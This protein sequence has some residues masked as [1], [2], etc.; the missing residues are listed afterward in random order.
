MTDKEKLV[1]RI[2]QDNSKLV[3]D[4]KD[5]IPA[6]WRLEGWR[7][8]LTLEQNFRRV[9]NPE[10]ITRARRKLHENGD[11]KYSKQSEDKRY[12]LYKE[13][14]E[15]YSSDI[16]HFGYSPDSTKRFVSGD[17]SIPGVGVEIDQETNT[18]RLF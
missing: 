17:S 9:S 15:E 8:D 5:L 13:K 11:I 14:T 1:Y 18:A 16:I 2:Y 12:E 6:V 3:D 10:S 4:D 7:D